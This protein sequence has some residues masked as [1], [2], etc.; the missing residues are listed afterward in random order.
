MGVATNW[1][2][3]HSQF[4]LSCWFPDKTT[5]PKEV[6]FQSQMSHAHCWQ[7]HRKRFLPGQNSD[8][9]NERLCLQMKEPPLSKASGLLSICQRRYPQT[10]KLQPKRGFPF[11]TTARQ[12]GE[13]GNSFDRM[14]RVTASFAR[15]FF[16]RPEPTPQT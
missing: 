1:T 8:W 7:G 2:A 9:I 10:T 5:I 11:E 12:V 13:G 3:G 6:P 14:P 4:L 16:L 15:V